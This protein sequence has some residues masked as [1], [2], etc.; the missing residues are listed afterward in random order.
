MAFSCFF[1]GLIDYFI[2]FL[3]INCESHRYFIYVESFHKYTIHILIHLKICE[4]MCLCVCV[5]LCVLIQSFQSSLTW[6]WN[7]NRCC[8]F[9]NEHTLQNLQI[10]FVWISFSQRAFCCICV[11]F[12]H[13]CACDRLFLGYSV[14][15]CCVAVV[16]VFGTTIQL[17]FP[18]VIWLFLPQR[19][20]SVVFSH[21]KILSN[22]SWTEHLK[23]LGFNSMTF[24]N[25]CMVCWNIPVLKLPKNAQ[26]HTG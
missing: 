22:V 12:S 19:E 4:P 1:L 11:Y 7:C 25:H 15:C 6:A 8:N 16:D 17:L 5:C 2:G 13:D 18:W 23:C 26:Q 21:H 20:N 24:T 3:H 14:F 9:Y 10:D